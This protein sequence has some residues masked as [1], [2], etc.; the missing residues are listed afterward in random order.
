MRKVNQPFL[1][2][3]FLEEEAQGTVE[4]LLILS[5]CV[6]GAAEFTRQ[7]VKI[8]DKGV[9]HLGADLEKDLKTGRAPISVWEN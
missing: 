4:Y 3:F 1:M 9:L 7:L 6:I 8:I 2:R 5:A